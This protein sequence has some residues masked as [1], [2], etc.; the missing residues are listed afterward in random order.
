[1]S[2]VV[3]PLGETTHREAWVCPDCSVEIPRDNTYCRVCLRSRPM[4]RYGVPQI[5]AGY[6]IHFNGVIPRAIK[7][8]SHSVEWR[9]AERHGAICMADFDTTQVN[10]LIYR[11]GYERSIKVRRCVEGENKNIPA[12]PITWMLDCLLQSRQIHAALYRL[13]SIPAVAQ[14][15][16]N[17]P[18]LPHHQHPYYLINMEEYAISTSF[19][20]KQKATDGTRTN[21]VVDT[22]AELPPT[23]KIPKLQYTNVNV[24]RAVCNTQNGKATAED[25]E[26]N[27]EEA[28]EPRKRVANIEILDCEQRKN[29][30]DNFL[31]GGMKFVLTPSLES[32]PLVARALKICGAKIVPLSA[33]RL[34]KILRTDVTH[35]LYDH[36]EKKCDVMV[37]AAH[38]KK[39]FPGLTLAQLNWAE[40]CL[41]LG[42]VV[43]PYG[44]YVPTEKLLNTLAKRYTRR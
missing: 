42:E 38:I 33:G 8:P 5:F 10:L 21:K 2:S 15:T 32:N 12:V 18:A 1:M 35:V 14:P 24:F 17:G 6:K 26:A 22:N 3:D 13:I 40:D 27:Y 20:Y 39:D 31:F 23:L 28:G 37:E 43:P 34:D 7:H 19:S 25:D 30:V 29:C 9:M 36:S 4:D 11:P 16:G 44:H 41:I